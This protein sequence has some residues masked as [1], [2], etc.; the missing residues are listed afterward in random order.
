[1]VATLITG[2]SHSEKVELTEP[3]TIELLSEN[4]G[5]KSLFFKKTMYLCPKDD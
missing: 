4:F 5:W 1:M 2:N 3:F